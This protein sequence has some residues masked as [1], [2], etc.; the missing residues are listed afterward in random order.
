MKEFQRDAAIC[1]TYLAEFFEDFK[2][3]CISAL[4]GEAEA[5][6]FLEGP[7][8]ETKEEEKDKKKEEPFLDQIKEFVGDLRN[9]FPKFNSTDLDDI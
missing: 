6:K 7:A 4:G 8:D 9:H 2:K 1:H 3:D 5:K